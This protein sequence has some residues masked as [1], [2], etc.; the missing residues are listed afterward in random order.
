[1]EDVWVNIGVLRAS[2]PG[3]SRRRSSG[4]L[5]F[6]LEGIWERGFQQISYRCSGAILSDVVLSGLSSRRG[7][8]RQRW[9]EG[10]VLVVVV[11]D[12]LV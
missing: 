7:L 9:V 11:V 2:S 8:S 12:G 10:E 1:M 5:G 4:N 3:L 6:A